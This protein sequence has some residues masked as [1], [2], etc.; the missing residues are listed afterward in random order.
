MRY[1]S[2][3]SRDHNGPSSIVRTGWIAIKSVRHIYLVSLFLLFTAAISNAAVVVSHFG[4]ANPTTEGWTA[5]FPTAAVTAKPGAEDI[6]AE[7][8]EAP[9][10]YWRIND[11]STASSTRGNYRYTINDDHF[12]H[13]N[14]WS[15]RARVKRVQVTTGV[16]ENPSY[17]AT[18]FLRKF[19]NGST[20]EFSARFGVTASGLLRM[21]VMGVGE[22][23]LNSIA[24]YQLVEI[25]FDPV[26]NTVDYLVDGQLILPNHS[27][28]TLAGNI[29]VVYWGSGSSP[30]TAQSFWHEVIFETS[31]DTDGDGLADADERRTHGTDPYLADTDSDG[32]NDGDEVAA[33][34]DPFEKDTDGDNLLDGFEIQYGLLPTTP[35][36][37][38]LD[39]D[40]DGLSAY[41]EQTAGS[42][43]LLVDTDSDEISDGDEV[44]IYESNPNSTDS[45]GDGL[46]DSD[47]V[48]VHNS[49]PASFDTDTDG[50]ND[51]EELN[52]YN[53]DLLNSDSD[54]DG[55][56]D[57][58]E[59][60][61]SKTDPL[62]PDS[63]GD[64]L[65]DGFEVRYGFDP[66]QAGEENIDNDEDTLDNLAEQ[67]AGTNPVN[68]DSDGDGLNDNDELVVY[69]SDPT[70]T[71]SDD[72]GLTDS[73]EVEFSLAV[74][75]SGDA[76]RD[77]D[78]DGL[79]NLEEQSLRTDPQNPD[80]DNDGV[81]DG[82]EVNIANSNP[83]YPDAG[84][85]PQYA[86]NSVVFEATQQPLFINPPPASRINLIP[87]ELVEEA[88]AKNDYSPGENK[89]GKVVNVDGEVP[90]WA[91]Q[92]AWD[93]GWN[94]C[95]TTRTGS[96]QAQVG[97][98]VGLFDACS[99]WSYTPSDALCREGGSINLEAQSVSCCVT[100]AGDFNA[101]ASYDSCKN[102]SDIFRDSYVKNFT[103][104]YVEG[105]YSGNQIP[106][107]VDVPRG[108]GSRPTQ[109]PPAAN[110]TAGA[111][112]TVDVSVNADLVLSAESQDPGEF[113][114]RYITNVALR[115][116][117]TSVT[118][119]D[120]FKVWLDHAP[121]KDESSMSSKWAAI[122]FTAGYEITGGVKATAEYWSINPNKAASYPNPDF[123]EHGIFTVIDETIYEA[124]EFI[125][126]T[127]AASEGVPGSG[128]IEFRFMNGVDAEAVPDFM[129][130]KTFDITPDIIDFNIPDVTQNALPVIHDVIPPGTGLPISIP[131]CVKA[132]KKNPDPCPSA[133]CPFGFSIKGFCFGLGLA[134]N[135]FSTF[136]DVG[137]ST[138]VVNLR[139]QLPEVNTPV[140]EGFWGGY[141]GDI[142]DLKISDPLRGSLWQVK[143]PKRSAIEEDGSLVNTVPSGARPVINYT[144]TTPLKA[145]FFDNTL[146][147]SDTMRFQWDLDGTLG[148]SGALFDNT[149]GNAAISLTA[150]VFDVDAVVWT[151]IDQTLTFKPGLVADLSFNMPVMVRLVSNDPALNEDTAMMINLNETK[152]VPARMVADLGASSDPDTWLEVTQPSG[153]LT[154]TASYSFRENTFTNDTRRIVTIAPTLTVL[155]LGI[156]G[157]VGGLIQTAAGSSLVHGPRATL[158]TPAVEKVVLGDKFNDVGEVIDE[159]GNVIGPRS[160]PGQVNKFGGEQMLTIVER[161]R[162]ADVDGLPDTLEQASCTNK[163]DIDSDDDGISDG[164]EDINRNGIVD[165][166]ETD[167]CNVDSDNDGVQ[168]GTEKGAMVGFSDPDG[169]GPLLGTDLSIFI[170]D[171]DPTVRSDPTVANNTGGGN[172]GNGGGGSGGGALLPATLGLLLFAVLVSRSF[173]YRTRSSRNRR[174]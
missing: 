125:G 154:I 69:N 124:G 54:N 58:Q 141:E 2:R 12:N 151:G 122:G 42:S 85:V 108:L 106:N 153:D 36:D 137:T 81:I 26:S 56:L 163:L 133:P 65:L 55:A 24:N 79:T 25:V 37:D 168:D 128:K 95:K 49:N 44:L 118:A 104:S 19:V 14:G 143:E 149:Y 72:D 8:C 115:A 155:K 103:L 43:P 46:S 105:L 63:D 83:L 135:Y 166:G 127:A 39:T 5:E 131:R 114:I 142:T 60:A 123:Q 172:N 171:P 119:D 113:D 117:N 134:K 139:F 170:A 164:I 173:R 38:S 68:P 110:Y 116:D 64:G 45:D 32:A 145:L 18:L 70:K 17:A 158:P 136:F 66:N 148:G 77:P 100:V 111:E 89:Y 107:T 152:T 82:Q 99:D 102:Q 93:K 157:L 174:L 90:L 167:P 80:T 4:D 159:L 76:I 23:T 34:S 7:G 144:D 109:A 31:P 6:G 84:K 9:C 78:S 87:Q 121:I 101:L 138:E 150:G 147:S 96:T 129:K 51:F 71:D 27:G 98:V 41:E 169:E 130:D 92:E 161:A 13:V 40:S 156:G 160:V 47:E 86:K 62:N 146:F 15:L 11:P 48:T 35:D 112:V 132:N 53:T 50:L 29:N 20:R 33:L 162:D 126:F 67:L 91:Y 94:Q 16:A 165:Q 22:F 74:L 10:A 28:H 57:G 75:T 140:S 61:I 59:I 88:M 97:G 120:T 30:D 73:F 21:E 1:L 3:S 52:T